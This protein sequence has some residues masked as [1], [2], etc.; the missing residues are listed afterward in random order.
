MAFGIYVHVPFCAKRC[1]YCAFATYEG[2]DDLQGAYV[3]AVLQEIARAQKN[4]IIPPATSIFFGGGTPSR[5]TPHDVGRILSALDIASDAE[6]TA[7]CNPEDASEER[8]A[9]W[10]AAGINRVSFGVQSVVAHVL[11]TL[12]R[13]HRP[14]SVPHALF[15]AHEAGFRSYNADLIYGTPGESEEDFERSVRSLIEAPFAPPHL[16]VYALTPEPGTPLG[17][18]PTRHPTEDLQA[19][20]YERAD[21]LLE[22]A[23]YRWEE[24]SNWAK[25]GH[26]CRHN[27]LYWEQG[28]YRG[29][30]SAAHSHHDGRR[31]WNVRTP[32]RYI[33][34]VSAG[35]MPIG[36]EEILDDATAAFER[37]FLALRMPRGVPKTA[38][39]NDGELEGLVTYVGDRAALTVRGRLLANAVAQRLIDPSAA[40]VG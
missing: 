33:A 35:R 26:E 30:G 31:F 15:L 25:P 16:S 27:H 38:L 24:I 2:K 9:I 14:E 7:E 29:F 34:E 13:Q 37:L 28:N 17:E 32:E 39:R 36:G 20:R 22:M 3:D 21:A 4:E 6:V 19:K 5:L 40:R 10:R 12:G 8:F 18:D 1:D 11:E 23:G